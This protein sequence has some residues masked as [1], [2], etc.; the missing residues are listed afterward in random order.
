MRLL[1]VD[2][3]YYIVEYI[4]Y[5]LEWKK[6][7]INSITTTTNPIE[8]KALLE[9]EPISILITDIRMP[10]VSGLDLL[11]HINKKQLRTKVI[12]LSGYSEFEYSQK[13]IRLG[14]VDYLL[15][16]VDKDDLEKTI[17]LVINKMDK[18]QSDIRLEITSKDIVQIEKDRKCTNMDIINTVQAYIADH[19]SDDISLDELGKVVY[20]HPV[21]LSKLYK[22]ETGENLSN[23]IPRKRLEKASKLLLDSNLN[24]ID[25]SHLVGYKKPQYFIMLFKH[26]YGFTPH[27]Y[28]RNRIRQG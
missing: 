5:L 8:A 9:Q 25:I 7:G 17:K 22:Q 24:V 19:L 23:Y 4:K 3:G 1:I 14:A 2:D 27:Q 15:K 21:Y 18:H 12:I 28:R 11:E 16:P 6:I 26:Q 13:A 10:E 20:L